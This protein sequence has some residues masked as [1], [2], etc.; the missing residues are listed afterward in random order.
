MPADRPAKCHARARDGCQPAPCQS[1]SANA[2]PI[3]MAGSFVQTA[4]ATHAPA[5]HGRLKYASAG[6]AIAGR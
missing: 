3:R 4:M 1:V 6:P 2:G 5:H